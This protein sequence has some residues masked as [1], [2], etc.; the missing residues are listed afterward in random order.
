[1]EYPPVGYATAQPRRRHVQVMGGFVLGLGLGLFVALA[2]YAVDVH[3]MME[4]ARDR[5]G[6]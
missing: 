4:A 6:M 3:G 2:F 1:M 5:F